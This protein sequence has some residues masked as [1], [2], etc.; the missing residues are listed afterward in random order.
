MAKFPGITPVAVE[1]TN[2]SPSNINRIEKEVSYPAI[3]K[4]ANLFSSLLIQV[5][6]NQAELK[7]S[8][9][10]VFTKIKETYKQRGIHESPQIIVEQY[11]EGECYSIDAYV[12][13]QNQVF[14]CPPVRYIP[15]KQIGI[16]DFFLYKR[17]VPTDLSE[18][19]IKTANTAVKKAISALGLTY[20]SAHVELIRS[21]RGWKII[22]LGPRI[23]RFR[24]LM[25]RL[26]YGIDHSLNDAKI[27]LGLKPDIPNKLIKYCAAYSIYPPKEGK[28]KIINGLELLKSTQEIK[29]LQVFSQPGDQALFA[30]NGGHALAEFLVVSD[31]K[32]RFDEIIKEVE[33]QAHAVID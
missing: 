28:L 23:G 4:P 14:F 2:P 26:A 13:E 27:H 22:E 30:K 32:K 21:D 31:D 33:K 12:M 20:S 16:D 1:I 25:Y 17:Y 3:I 11:I 18:S 7:K 19:D 5:C 9:A 29:N 6:N 10:S 24:H 8:L 15:A